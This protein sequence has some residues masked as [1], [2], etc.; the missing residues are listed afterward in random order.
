MICPRRDHNSGALRS[1]SNVTEY[2]GEF[3]TGTIRRFDLYKQLG[4]RF[5]DQWRPVLLA[6]EALRRLAEKAAADGLPPPAVMQSNG[7]VCDLDEAAAH[8]ARLLLSGPARR[9]FET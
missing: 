9:H 5:R 1:R 7:G 3:S 2:T 8:P 4:A 6:D